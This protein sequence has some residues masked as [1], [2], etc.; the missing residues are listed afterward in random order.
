MSKIITNYNNGDQFPASDANQTF[1]A[2]NNI[3]M[4]IAQKNA[5]SIEESNNNALING[6]NSLTL[7]R[8]VAFNV[9]GSA[10]QI[11]LTTNTNYS[12][13]PITKYTPFLKFS[14]FAQTTN[15][16]SITIRIDGLADIIA[17]RPNGTK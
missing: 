4:D 1:V 8:E 11:I 13:L 9:S 12:S 10:N 6:L 5:V 16:G 17:E 3:L 7:C 15:T 14:F 2:S